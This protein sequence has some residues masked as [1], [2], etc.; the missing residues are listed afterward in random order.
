MKLIIEKLDH[1]LYA[2]VE[3]ERYFKGNQ[4]VR[5]LASTKLDP[6]GLNDNCSLEDMPNSTHYVFNIK[7]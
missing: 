3:A 2:Y 7:R 6:K 1:S 5:V 4:A